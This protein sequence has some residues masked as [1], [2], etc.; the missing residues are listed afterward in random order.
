MYLHF[1]RWEQ[2][3]RHA[4][5]IFDENR[6]LG[7]YNAAVRLRISWWY[8]ARQWC[9][10][11]S[12]VLA[13]MQGM[14]SLVSQR[15]SFLISSTWDNCQ[16]MLSVSIEVTLCL[17]SV[18]DESEHWASILVWKREFPLFHLLLR[19]LALFLCTSKLDYIA[20]LTYVHREVFLALWSATGY[21]N[22][23]WITS[24]R[25]RSML[26]PDCIHQYPDSRWYIGVKVEISFGAWPCMKQN[27]KKRWRLIYMSHLPPDSSA[28]M[29]NRKTTWSSDLASLRL[30]GPFIL[31]MQ[32]PRCFGCLHL[33]L[34][35]IWYIVLL[36]YP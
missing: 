26:F 7:S 12:H 23:R 3:D 11:L 21:G 6:S 5:V 18:E 22:S 20:L 35:R 8:L 9:L 33:Q 30:E 1:D 15:P 28:K 19:S 10:E 2:V 25:K 24:D 32:G 16:I 27:I 4:H 36:L 13:L 31:P 34:L 17:H 14:E 29:F